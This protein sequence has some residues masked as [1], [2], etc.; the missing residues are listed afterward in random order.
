MRSL[1]WKVLLDIIFISSHVAYCCLVF[2]TAHDTFSWKYLAG[3]GNSKVSPL[4]RKLHLTRNKIKEVRSALSVSCL[5]THH[6]CTH[7][8]RQQAC[9]CIHTHTHTHRYVVTK[10]VCGPWKSLKS[11]FLH[12]SNWEMVYY[13]LWT[14]RWFWKVLGWKA[15]TNVN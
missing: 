11:L 14:F 10:L 8:H 2:V 15:P 9:I 13:W 1:G 3:L 6:A 4:K 5:I 12:L 7:M